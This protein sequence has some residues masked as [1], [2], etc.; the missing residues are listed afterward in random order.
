MRRSAK[1]LGFLAIIGFALANLGCSK[2]SQ[3][4]PKNDDKASAAI[5]V[6]VAHVETGSIAAYFTGTATLE[7]EEDASVVAKVGGVVKQI[8]VE[9][10][11]NVKA[12]QILA[13]LDD[14]RSAVQLAQAEANLR[15]LENDFHRHE[16]LFNK[17]LI[18]AEVYQRAKFEHESQKAA[19]DMTKLEY[20]YAAIRA[21]ISGVVAQR[22]IKVGNMVL[23]N[24]PTFRITDFD[25]LLAVLHVP[26]REMSKLRVG[27]P[28]SLT[29]DAIAGTDFSGRIARVSPV[30]DPTTGTIKVTVEVR[31][32]SR[33]LKAG[34]FGR[35]NIVH[36]VHQNALLVPKGAV[37]A[38]DAE[39][40][41]FVVQD[42]LAYRKLVKTG[43]VNGAHIEILEG[44]KAGEKIVTTGQGSLKDSSKVEV[45]KN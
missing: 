21:P 19:F 29:V 24:T 34:M 17:K 9:E 8:L 3:S 7:A 20:D 35:V 31:D 41:I 4:K 13:K 32:P 1:V 37:L 45:V 26:E 16:E 22:M 30:V 43:Y 28:A 27:Q 11:V 10:G 15:K 36:D 6:E 23:P 40:A 25:P 2:D 5:P 38:E 39:S 44:L 42:S 18:S 12:G 14:E 33:Q